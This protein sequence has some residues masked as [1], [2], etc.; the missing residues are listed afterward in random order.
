MKK[1][2]VFA[3]GNGSNYE[4]IAAACAD[5]RINAECALLVC[6]KPGAFVL[7]RAKKF[8]TPAFVFSSVHD[9]AVAPVFFTMWTTAPLFAVP[10]FTV[11]ASVASAALVM[12]YLPPPT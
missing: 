3:S 6:D 9:W 2:A 8:G 11:R 4:A 7:E 10:P 12:T 1:I 5:G